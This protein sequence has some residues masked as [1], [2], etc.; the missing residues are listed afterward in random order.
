MVSFFSVFEKKVV[1]FGENTVTFW[2]NI[3]YTVSLFALCYISQ[4]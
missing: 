4:L 1:V 3:A 2:H